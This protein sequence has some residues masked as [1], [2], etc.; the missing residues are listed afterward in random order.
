[1]E[2]EG[3]VDD[4]TCSPP[5]LKLKGSRLALERFAPKSNHWFKYE[6]TFM[7]RGF[8]PF[9]PVQVETGDVFG[10]HQK[11]R[12]LGTRDGILVLPKI[13]P[14]QR[15]QWE[16]NRALGNTPITHRLF[17]DP[18][19]FSGIRPY[20]EGDPLNRI[21]WRATARTGDL[22]TR[23][24]DPTCIQG[25]TL[26][27]DF[28]SRSIDDGKALAEAELLITTTASL[29]HAFHEEGEQ[30]GLMALAGNKAER[31]QRED[32]ESIKKLNRTWF[33]RSKKDLGP[34]EESMIVPTRKGDHQFQV[35]KEALAKME[36]ANDATFREWIPHYQNRLPRDASVIVISRALSESVLQ[37]IVSLKASGFRTSFIRVN[38]QTDLQ[39]DW[40]APTPERAELASTGIPCFH[41]R[42]ED[43]IPWLGSNVTPSD[44]RS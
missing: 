21:H 7:A 23:I 33:A 2:E 11:R 31:I 30:V 27:V 26:V 28:N 24:F 18:T 8:Y 38:W 41:V 36:F 44:A 17:E 14:I 20:Q 37:G 16:S 32:L 42:Q 19:R 22:Q 10:L 15:N 43:D 9:G 3:P 12:T 25:A 6:A 39:P 34:I 4:L 40:A 5:K 29:A 13:V 35:I 1:M